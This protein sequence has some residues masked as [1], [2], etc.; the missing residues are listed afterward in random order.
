MN[1]LWLSH[2]VPYPPRGGVLQRSYHLLRELA[3]R[4]SVSLWAIVQPEWFKVTHGDVESG[5]TEAREEFSKLC[6]AVHFQRL[7]QLDNAT[8]FS[9]A[10]SY[11]RPGGYT[12]NWLRSGAAARGLADFVDGKKFDAIHVDTVSLHAYRAILPEIPATL[13]HHNIESHMMVRRAELEPSAVKRMM[14]G[15]EARRL[16]RYERSVAP[17]YDAHIVCSAL[18]A[19]RLKASYGQLE[20]VVVPNAVDIEFFSPRNVNEDRSPSLVFAGNMSWYPNRDAMLHF[21]KDIWPILKDK[22]PT[23]VM[24]LVGAHT[25]PELIQLSK[26]DDRFNVLGFVDEVRDPMAEAAVYVCPIRDGGGTKLKILDALAMGKAIVAHPVACEGIDV[27][28]GLN[29]ILAEDVHEF[30]D[31]VV[32]LVD[33]H[34]RRQSLETEARKLAVRKYSTTEIGRV[35]SSTYEKIQSRSRSGDLARVAP[36]TAERE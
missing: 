35:L 20:T 11:C 16:I 4:H 13:T 19:D 22:V 5:L 21:A 6:S 36:L 17:S 2:V 27:T 1:I 34:E 15:V 25:P 32:E 3:L 9:Q 33:N 24:N 28:D 29:V 14:F 23:L 8:V 18:D 26:Q 12:A 10:A 31:H 30:A 7:S